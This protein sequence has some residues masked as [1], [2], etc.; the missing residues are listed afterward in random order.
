MINK[1]AFA[2]LMIFSIGISNAQTNTGSNSRDKL[3]IGA[4]IGFNYSN[5]YDSKGEEFNADSKFGMAIGGFLA[6]PIGA[7]FGV[8]PEIL[9]GNE[10]RRDVGKDLKEVENY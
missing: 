1:I 7:Y 9:S 6:I 2:V 8:Q 3:H 4:K 10:I 5:V